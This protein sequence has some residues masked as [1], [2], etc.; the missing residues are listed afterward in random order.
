MRK[1][2]KLNLYQ[3]LYSRTKAFYNNKGFSANCKVEWVEEGYKDIKYLH[4]RG[5]WR[6][7][8]A[9]SDNF[10]VLKENKDEFRM[11]TSDADD[12]WTKD[13]A[14]IGLSYYEDDASIDVFDDILI[15]YCSALVEDVR[16]SRNQ[17]QKLK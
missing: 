5:Y 16:S 3:K 2:E 6:I 13:G 14:L 4:S 1:A 15:E 17:H 7:S 11:Y 8:F 12:K 9:D 10:Y